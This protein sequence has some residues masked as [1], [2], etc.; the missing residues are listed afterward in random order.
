MASYKATVITTSGKDLIADSVATGKKI[1]FTK[2]AFSAQGYDLLQAQILSELN[3][4]KQTVPVSD[5]YVSKGNTQFRKIVVSGTATN[6]DLTEGYYLNT[7][8]LY[9]RNSS[10]GKEIL[11][12]V[13]CADLPDYMPPFSNTTLSSKIFKFYI[14]VSSTANISLEVDPEGTANVGDVRELQSQVAELQAYVGYSDEDIYGVEV[15]FLNKKFTRLAGAVNDGW[16]NC[17]AIMMRQRTTINDE[18]KVV[19]NDDSQVMVYQPKFYYKVVPLVVDHGGGLQKVRY[20]IS[21]FKRE[22]FKIHPAFVVD[23]KEVEH[24]YLAAYE[25][26]GQN[27]KTRVFNTDNSIG[28]SDDWMLASIPNAHPLTGWGYQS[29]LSSGDRRNGQ[30]STNSNWSMSTIQSISATQLLYLI[31]KASFNIQSGLG[32][33]RT[34]HAEV[35]YT[36]GTVAL[37]NESGSL[38]GDAVSYRGEENIFGNVWTFI[39]GITITRSG[40]VKIGSKQT[41]I[42][43]KLTGTDFVYSFYYSEEYDW[44]FF[45]YI[46]NGDSS[47]PVGDAIFANKS[48]STTIYPLIGGGYDDTVRAGLFALYCDMD[49]DTTGGTKFGARLLY[50]PTP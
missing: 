45:P 15:D 32:I 31:E 42:P 14:S 34:Q 46:G 2:I 18:G 22:G 4:I 48:T 7:V 16:K 20:Y 38:H 9:A 50:T 21:D 41:N 27:A 29:F 44:L 25:A 28:Y 35:G 40:G 11:Y 26:C 3:N 43:F 47:L 49:N 33:G 10:N 37:E 30:Y 12:A 6:V 5:I 1:E 24:I 8:G 23:G 19:N 13:C 39:Q 17:M 36:G